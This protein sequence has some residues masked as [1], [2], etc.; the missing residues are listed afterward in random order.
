MLVARMI[1]PIHTLGPGERIGLW[2]QGCSKNCR[3][4]ISKELQIF[5]ESKNIPIDILVSLIKKEADRSKCR[6]ITISGGDPFEQPEELYEL[7]VGI[8]KRFKDILV[9]TGYTMSEIKASEIMYK[10]FLLIDVLVDGRYIEEKNTGKSRIYGSDNQKIF[11]QKE[12]LVKDYQ[13][14]EKGERTLETFIHE[15]RVITVG[16]QKR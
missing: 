16:I 11:I 9:Y 7:L 10:C 14:F 12:E 3:G 5:D 4:C 1:S 6:R 13:E 8:R 2:I 15:N